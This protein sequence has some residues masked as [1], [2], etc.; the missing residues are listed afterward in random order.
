MT[1]KIRIQLPLNISRGLE[2][3]L[4]E[5]LSTHTSDYPGEI[6]IEN[7]HSCGPKDG[8]KNTSADIYIGFVPELIKKTDIDIR[9]HFKVIAHCFE[10]STYLTTNGFF[11]TTG[12]FLPFGIVPFIIFYNPDHTS[13]SELPQTWRDLLNPKWENRIMMP[14]AEH[15]AAKVVRTI[16]SDENPDL[17]ESIDK[18]I[19][20]SGMPPNVID[21]VKKGNY[22]LGITNIT[23]GKISEAHRIKLIWP[24]DG[25]MSMPQ[26]M[27]WKGDI[28]KRFL[29][30]GAFMLSEPVQ[31]FLNQQ[32]FITAAPD[33]ALP[34]IFR[35]QLPKLKWSGWSH[36]RQAMK[37]CDQT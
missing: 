5:H 33:M 22:A 4:Q 13:E 2:E 27:A 11:D 28:D 23:F 35:N 29:K 34:E 3:M 24:E 6:C 17:T 25:L 15:M 7:S 18:N 1:T 26:I 8:K 31:S 14:G 9:N 36:F 32:S 19:S 16:L 21:N 20:F 10:I 12:C 37:S 30:L